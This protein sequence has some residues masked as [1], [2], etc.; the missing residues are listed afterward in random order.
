MSIFS[1]II[2]SKLFYLILPFAI[3]QV[4]LIPGFLINFFFK[5]K[6]NFFSLILNCLA[7]SLVL[8]YCIIFSLTVFGIYNSYII[9]ILI[10]IEFLII[11]TFWKNIYQYIKINLKNTIYD[12]NLLI[13]KN[14]T[15]KFIFYMCLFLCGILIVNYIPFIK[16][17][18]NGYVQIFD[19]GD[20][21]H[22]YSQH[23]A[24]W[25]KGEI[26]ASQFLKPQLWFSNVSLIYIIFNNVYFEP[27]A[28]IIFILVPFYIFIGTLGFAISSKN[29]IFLFSGLIG[30]NFIL[31]NTYSFSTSGYLEIPQILGFLIF[32]IFIYDEIEN[33]YNLRSKNILYVFV[34]I[35]LFNFLT[36]EQ[37]WIISLTTVIF[38]FY[39]QKQLKNYYFNF[40]II[41]KSLLIFISV[42]L[43][44]Y[45]YNFFYDPNFKGAF[46]EVIKLITFDEDFHN[47]AAH[48]TEFLS[49]NTRLTYALGKYP[50]FLIIPTIALL[51]TKNKIQN[52]F[53][54]SFIVPYLV[55][56]IFVMSNEI[57]Y[58]YPLYFFIILFGYKNIIELILIYKK[59][60]LSKKKI[61]MTFLTIIF[62]ITLIFNNNVK[63]Y[64]EFLNSITYKKIN[65]NTDPDDINPALNRVIVDYFKGKKITKNEKIT[66]NYYLLKFLNIPS[67]SNIQDNIIYST[68]E[69][70]KDLIK[71]KYIIVFKNC[72]EFLD[73]KLIQL[74][75]KKE[76]ALE[77]S[78]ILLNISPNQQFLNQ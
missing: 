61:I 68:F 24:S 59:K 14:L 4:L 16:E 56:W 7:T 75:F 10:F 48:S 23:A 35:L 2:F 11:I 50:D 37:S 76:K 13:S 31:S 53:T 21:L 67:L 17:E 69:N 72:S 57:R 63:N 5:Y 29:I 60:F 54:Y 45:I 58:L 36:K 26:P 1:D 39:F 38:Y 28:K 62:L 42:F 66:T 65:I 9:W 6:I 27:F 70:S 51:F 3:L 41:F 15:N 49:L 33:K 52:T 12:F 25:F 44:Y 46:I 30:L 55:F 34:I 73:K 74:N 32:L 71:T 43:S 19:M 20:V 8:N 18:T 40:N 47:R 77:N 22:N 64:S 78:C